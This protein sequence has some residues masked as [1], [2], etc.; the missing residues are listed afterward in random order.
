MNRE[1]KFRAW[2]KVNKKWRF[3]KLRN[4]GRETIEDAGARIQPSIFVGLMQYTGLKDKSG[5][6]IYEGD[7]IKK[8]NETGGVIFHNSAFRFKS[9]DIKRKTHPTLVMYADDEVVGNIHENPNLIKQN[10]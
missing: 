6:E 10:P 4:S 7:I 5:R 8:H 9:K 2:D 1:I 3:I